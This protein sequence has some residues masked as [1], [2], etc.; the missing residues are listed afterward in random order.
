MRGMPRGR[1]LRRKKAPPD[2]DA[3]YSLVSCCCW[4]VEPAVAEVDAVVG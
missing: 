1:D 4:D 3:R 2:K